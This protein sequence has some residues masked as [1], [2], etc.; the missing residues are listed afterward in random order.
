MLSPGISIEEL[1]E[2]LTFGE[3][4]NNKAYKQAAENVVSS[5]E[6]DKRLALKC[7]GNPSK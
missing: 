1:E 2:K 7:I 3:K 6:P 5:D 4:L